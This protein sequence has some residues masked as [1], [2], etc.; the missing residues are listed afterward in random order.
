MTIFNDLQTSDLFIAA[1]ASLESAG[2]KTCI[3]HG[4][5]G[6]PGHIPSD[7]DFVILP[8][9]LSKIPAIFFKL[10]CLLV[11]CLQHES[12]AYY[13]VLCSTS[14]NDVPFFL[15]PDVSG[16]Y[17]LSGCVFLT[18]E[19]IITSR[20]RYK[21][22]WIPSP[23]VEFAYYLIK[24]IAKGSID[25]QQRNSLISLYQQDPGGCQK[26]IHRFWSVKAAQ[27]LI[28]AIKSNEWTIVYTQSA[29][30]RKDL[31][32]KAFKKKPSGILVYWKDDFFR[33]VKRVC[34]RTGLHIVVL[35][36]DGSGKSSI[37]EKVKADLA[38][39]FRRTL[40]FHL[41]P[42]L[43]KARRNSGPVTNPHRLA[44]YSV[45]MSLLKLCYFSMDYVFGYFVK[46]YSMLVRSTLVLFD[47]YYHDI[48]VD[49]KRYRY[50]GPMW[51]AR[52]VGKIIPK[53]DLFILLDAPPEV[54][55]SR[56]QEVPFEETARQREA[57]L[58]LVRGLE[59]GVVVDA[60]MPLD[61][62]VA[63]VNRMILSFMAERTRKRIGR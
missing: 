48:L 43:L 19:E 12:T 25:E 37:L 2:V 22:F 59:N 41:R 13:Y 58:E 3:L 61:D 16:D 4:Y 32:T 26:Q 49:P 36:A 44:N 15:H 18:A 24:K 55:Q 27:E 9:D 52:L 21:S 50:G 17:R 42:S 63:E 62:V 23:D 57:Y 60:S 38:P 31:L 1:F 35:G 47:R 34:V 53:P 11:Q 5:E 40:L 56:K 29:W 30:F 39:A 20:R 28:S 10:P 8:E 6:Y 33:R 51:L 46:I 7:V 14:S 45:F 54:L